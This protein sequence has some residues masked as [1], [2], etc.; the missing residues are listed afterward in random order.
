MAER[1]PILESDRI[2]GDR[3]KRRRI[4]WPT[5]GRLVMFEPNDS[6]LL[7][8]ASRVVVGTGR[9]KL[10]EQLSRIAQRIQLLA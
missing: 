9:S 3:H 1:F 6:G 8:E 7:E 5:L 4:D 10:A 2:K